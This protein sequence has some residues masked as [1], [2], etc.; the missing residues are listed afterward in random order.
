[1]RLYP[2]EPSPGS[3]SLIDPLLI[4]LPA[5]TLFVMVFTNLFLNPPQVGLLTYDLQ[6]A[7]PSHNPWAAILS[8]SPFQYRTPN[9]YLYIIYERPGGEK[10]LEVLN[11]ANL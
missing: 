5:R 7:C 8:I 6:V 9:K 4:N 11:V 1:M 2:I 10:L 3:R